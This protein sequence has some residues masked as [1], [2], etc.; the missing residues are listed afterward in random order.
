[1]IANPTPYTHA[2]PNIT[3]RDRAAFVREARRLRAIQFDRLFRAVGRFVSGSLTTL[4]T[5][6]EPQPAPTGKG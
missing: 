5:G 4:L 1:M 6:A 3:R 2:L